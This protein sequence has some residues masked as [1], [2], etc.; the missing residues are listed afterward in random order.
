MRSFALPAIAVAQFG[1]ERDDFVQRRLEV[2]KVFPGKLE[3]DF[4]TEARFSR[5]DFDAFAGD[6]VE[7]A[8]PQAPAGLHFG[9]VVS[10][11]VHVDGAFAPIDRAEIFAAASIEIPFDGVAAPQMRVVG[12][13][14]LLGVERPQAGVKRRVVP[15]VK[16]LSRPVSDQRLLF[17]LEEIV[18]RRAERAG[19]LAKVA[20]DFHLG[21]STSRQAADAG[22]Q[23]LGRTLGLSKRTR[24]SNKAV[25]TTWR[26]M[27]I[28]RMGIFPGRSSWAK[29]AKFL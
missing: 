26:N 22:L 17:G 19:E 23:L 14:E 15:H 12:A 21:G 7:V 16:E 1:I 6:G 20:V 8:G 4:R 11:P 3:F 5:A 9:F 2:R 13:V 24:T 27:D 25:E 10:G 28:L 29:W 18:H